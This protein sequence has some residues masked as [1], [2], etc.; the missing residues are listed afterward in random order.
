MEQKSFWG[1]EKAQRTLN[2]SSPP[3]PA[4]QGR[5]GVSVE[6]GIMDTE[7]FVNRFGERCVRV[8]GNEFMATPRQQVIFEDDGWSLHYARTHGGWAN[9]RLYSK[10][11][12]GNTRVWRF[13]LKSGTFARTDEFERLKVEAPDM[14]AWVRRMAMGNHGPIPEE[15]NQQMIELAERERREEEAAAKKKVKR[16]KAEAI[17]CGEKYFKM[18]NDM[19]RRSKDNSVKANKKLKFV[20]TDF[21]RKYGLDKDAVRDFIGEVLGAG[22]VILTPEGF[23]VKDWTNDEVEEKIRKSGLAKLRTPLVRRGL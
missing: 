15:A 16:K 7:F 13:G 17:L 11:E 8:G 6:T 2:T 20:L 19:R 5:L 14:L 10:R 1:S 12:L 4:L 9:Y 18:L 23:E 22:V 3:S 21:P